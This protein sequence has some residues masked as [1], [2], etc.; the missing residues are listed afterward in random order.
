MLIRADGL[1]TPAT[2][3]TTDRDVLLAAIRDS[4]PGSTAANLSG[5]LEL[6]RSALDLATSDSGGQGLLDRVAAGTVGEVAFV[7][8]ARVP[9]RDVA[10]IRTSGIPGC[11]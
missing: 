4:R 11:G 1:P 8:T 9:R 7:G 5:A 10:Q 2:A 6:A 3:F